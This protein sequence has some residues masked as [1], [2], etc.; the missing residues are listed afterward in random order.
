MNK[1]LEIELFRYENLLFG[2]VLHM[3]ESLRGTG[4]LYSEDSIKIESRAVPALEGGVLYLRGVGED[5]DNCAF[6]EK[7]RSNEEAFEMANRIQRG[8]N[9][10]NNV[11]SISYSL[12]IHRV[13]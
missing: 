1:K 4:V 13:V 5:E 6:F 12:P 8:I 10:I 11:E 7:Y 2:K 3:D 9:Y